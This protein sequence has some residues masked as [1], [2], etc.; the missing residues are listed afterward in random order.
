MQ[1][2][3]ASLIVIVL[4]FFLA[5]LVYG[6]NFMVGLF[7]ENPMI[8]TGFLPAELPDAVVEHET[9]R[10]KFET[11]DGITLSG[12]FLRGTRRADTTIGVVVF[13]PEYGGTAESWRKYTQFLIGRGYVVFAFDFRGTGDSEVPDD[14]RALR[15]CSEDEVEDVLAAMRCAREHTGFKDVMAMGVSRGAV[16]TLAAIA[17]DKNVAAAV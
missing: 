11:R 3:L 10:V 12:L 5:L 9:E 16:A 17:R 13:A 7:I 2:V 6:L 14:Y 1:V 8:Q 15:W 4:V